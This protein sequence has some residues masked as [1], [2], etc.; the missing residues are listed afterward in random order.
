MENCNLINFRKD[1]NKSAEKMA[2]IIGVSKSFYE[3]VEHGDRNSSFNFMKKFKRAFPKA[4]TDKI[5]LSDSN[6]IDA[7]KKYI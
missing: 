3:K 6:T 5:F 1:Q 7:K 4:D 2:E